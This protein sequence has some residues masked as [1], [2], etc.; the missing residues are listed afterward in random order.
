MLTT[1]ITVIA[2]QRGSQISTLYTLHV[3]CAVCQVHL[4][5]SWKENKILRKKKKAYLSV[6]DTW[7]NEDL[8]LH[9][10]LDSIWLFLFLFSF[11]ENTE[12]SGQTSGERAHPAAI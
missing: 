12:N 7:V 10:G 5:K 6:S 11:A 2:S 4:S 8:F 3:H 9:R 1:R